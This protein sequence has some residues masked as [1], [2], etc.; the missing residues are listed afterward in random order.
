MPDWCFM[1]GENTG[2]DED[3][4][5]EEDSSRGGGRR[6]GGGR[7]EL[8]KKNPTFMEGVSGVRAV[9]EQPLLSEIQRKVQDMCGWKK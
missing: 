3:G 8:H 4:N 2:V 5:Q 9:T 1:E 7:R 6:G